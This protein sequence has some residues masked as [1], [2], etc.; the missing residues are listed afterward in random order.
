MFVSSFVHPEWR[1]CTPSLHATTLG[2]IR[3]RFRRLSSEDGK[4]VL[5][6]AHAFGRGFP[7]FQPVEGDD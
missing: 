4:I 2:T 7:P 6:R 3:R 5:A 1:H